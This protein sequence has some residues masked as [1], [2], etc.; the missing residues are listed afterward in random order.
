MA[1]PPPSTTALQAVQQLSAHVSQSPCQPQQVFVLHCSYAAQQQQSTYC[2]TSTGNMAVLPACMHL[3]SAGERISQAT[4][5][6]P[7]KTA[8]VGQQ[9]P[10]LVGPAR[11]CPLRS[12]QRCPSGSSDPSMPH[13]ICT[14]AAICT[15][16]MHHGPQSHSHAS[17]N[18]RAKARQH[19]A[20]QVV[21][22]VTQQQAYK[23]P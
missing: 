15:T 22:T 2:V 1:A 14:H 5:H 11:R 19:G 9:A 4:I 6:L 10:A 16:K 12:L 17:Q 23:T 21:P 13:L 7:A 8:L 20:Q 18:H 3:S